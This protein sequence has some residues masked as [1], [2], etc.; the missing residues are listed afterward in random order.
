MSYL[1]SVDGQFMISPPL[2]WFQIRNS[3]FYLEN[4]VTVSRDD[5]GIVLLVEEEISETDKGFD[6]VRTCSTAVPWRESFDCR[7][8]ERDAKAFVE[9][10]RE[11]DRSV[12]GEM[13][14]TST[15]Y[16]GDIWRV[17]IDK[18][19]ARKETARFTW[20]DGSEVRFN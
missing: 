12:S 7:N 11:I 3:R 18:N 14:V 1:A 17:V 19:G 6:T 8:L 2:E 10:M 5:P 9:A 13:V 4:K 16:A 15:E 20:P